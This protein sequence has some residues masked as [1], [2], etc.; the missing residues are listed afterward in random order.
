MQ[1]DKSADHKSKT[2]DDTIQL[3][4][5][6]KMASNKQSLNS[7]PISSDQNSSPK[8]KDGEGQSAS[9]NSFRET[10]KDVLEEITSL[11]IN[12][13]IVGQIPMKKFDIKDFYM[14]LVENIMYKTEE[15]LQDVKEALL[16]R[17]AKLKQKGLLLPQ[18]STT[19][20]LPKE[21]LLIE[22]YR[23]ELTQYNQDL[24][25]YKEAE[26]VF[27]EYKNSSD[28]QKKDKFELEQS[29]YRELAKRI[30]KLD[31][32][33]DEHG[34]I[35]PDGQMI[36]YFRKLWEFEQYVLNGERIYA[37][38]KFHL[39]GDL[40]NRFLDDL[41]IPS[42][43]KIDPKMAQLVFDL[44]R[45]GVENAQKQWSG[46]I[47]TCVNLVKSLMPFRTTK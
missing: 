19:P 36:R 8:P 22:E 32:K 6:R 34:E 9:L 42:K 47:E 4:P 27:N 17:S 40:T 31:I 20:L 46:L 33:K 23:A 26:R 16:G 45:Q 24:E 41:F 5:R 28:P 14:E 12:T 44:H 11:E 2:S 3:N 29:C 10:M 39:D 38:T 35:V 25:T 1:V 43:S 30:F 18:Q 21:A 13:M 15:G 7:S 37:Q